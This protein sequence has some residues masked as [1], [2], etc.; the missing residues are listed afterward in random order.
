MRRKL[1]LSTI[2]IA[3]TASLLG[4]GAF[5]KFS[6]QEKTET[7]S[8]A[9]GTLDLQIL[10][11]QPGFQ[12]PGYLKIDVSNAKPGDSN[13]AA[14]KYIHIKNV[15]TLPG[16]LSLRV[17][18]DSNDENGIVEPELGDPTEGV[19]ELGTEMLVSIDGI[20][21]MQNVPLAT[22]D[23]MG[24]VDWPYNPFTPGTEGDPS[25]VYSIPDTAGNEI[26]SDS[27][28]FHVEFKLEQL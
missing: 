4:V 12:Y 13:A 24:W 25:V 15:G 20:G 10:N 18:M 27:V 28:S 2:S 6:D 19:G 5:A 17:V 26:M 9:A 14:P 1:L 21:S 16:K 11:G 3:A 22:L 8:V 7:N 23:G